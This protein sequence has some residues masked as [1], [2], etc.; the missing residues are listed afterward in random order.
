MNVVTP[1][2]GARSTIDPF[3]VRFDN[4]S[5]RRVTGRKNNTIVRDGKISNDYFSTSIPNPK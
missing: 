1:E 4:S 5:K 3:S 2:I